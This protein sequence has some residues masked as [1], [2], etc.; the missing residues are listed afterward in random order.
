MRISFTLP[1]MEREAKRC[2]GTCFHYQTSPLPGQGWCRNRGLRSEH[3]RALVSRRDHRCY[4]MLDDYWEP[5][6]ELDKGGG[7]VAGGTSDLATTGLPFVKKRYIYAVFLSM[8][9]LFSAVALFSTSVLS[10]PVVSSPGK[11]SLVAE[12]KQDFW[13]R[14]GATVAIPSVI[15]IMV[16]SKLELIDSKAGEVLEPS[17]PSPAKWYKLRVESSGD[18]GWAYSGWV[19]RH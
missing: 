13:L 14:D 17:L 18:V 16:G 3:E 7:D 9:V 8:A 10:T 12:A 4:E 2:C 1:Q 11:P 15:Y 19:E 5:A 6:S